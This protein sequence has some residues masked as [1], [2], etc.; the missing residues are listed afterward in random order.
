MIEP[1]VTSPGLDIAWIHTGLAAVTRYRCHKGGAHRGEEAQ[2][3][4]VIALPLGGSFLKRGRLGEVLADANHAVLFND[5]EPYETGHPCGH[6]DHGVAMVLPPAAACALVGS[7]DPQGAE[8]PER[9]FQV[10]HAVL[11]AGCLPALRALLEALAHPGPDPL[12]VDE[13]I[14]DLAALVIGRAHRQRGVGPRREATGRAHRDQV[15]GVK[16]LINRRL[17]EALDLESIARAVGASPYHLS[18]LFKAHT[19][20]AIHQYRTQL[21]LRAAMARLAEG[22]EDLTELAL[23]LGFSSHAHLTATFSRDVGAP[24]SAFRARVEGCL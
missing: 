8:R 9:P 6:G 20:L 11:D 18:R 13:L 16:A 14:F 12:A 10:S 4:H 21:R 15:E 1:A 24:P 5:Q 17:G 2:E 7:W 22:A 23:D 3:G 19:G